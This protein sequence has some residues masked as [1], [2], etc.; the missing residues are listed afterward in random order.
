MRQKHATGLAVPFISQTALKILG[1]MG[2]TVAAATKMAQENPTMFNKML[3]NILSGAGELAPS[4]VFKD[5]SKIEEIETKEAWSKSFKD[6]PEEEIEKVPESTPEEKFQS[7]LK[8]WSRYRYKGIPPKLPKEPKGPEFGE[9]AKEIMIEEILNRKNKLR[10]MDKKGKIDFLKYF[11]KFAELYHGGNVSSA[12]REINP[13][14]RWGS[15]GPQPKYT[16]EGEWIRSI[17]NRAGY[18]LKTVGR[19]EIGDVIT[20]FT[21]TDKTMKSLTDNISKNPLYLDIE[22]GD[23]EYYNVAN[24]LRKLGVEP[25]DLNKQLFATLTREKG[26]EG[27]SVKAY[28]TNINVRQRDS[29]VPGKPFYNLKDIIL[30]VE[31][32]AL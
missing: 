31:N 11:E 28:K 2:I 22:V 9:F 5:Q 12:A 24:T 10:G 32:F 13:P 26:A 6:Q 4:E 17:A 20:D 21:I 3:S 1:S 29:G 7:Q 30:N 14:G 27:A 19:G 8:D 23:D 18:K 15:E 16:T 25:T